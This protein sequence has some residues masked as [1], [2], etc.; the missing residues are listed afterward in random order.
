VVYVVI[1]WKTR[2]GSYRPGGYYPSE[3]KQAVATLRG[4]GIR[5]MMLTGRQQAGRG[6]GGEGD[7][8]R[9]YFAEVPP[10]EKAAIVKRFNRAGCRRIG[11]R[12]GE[13]TPPLLPRR[14][15]N[16]DRRRNRIGRNG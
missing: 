8:N 10:R 7:R 14:R 11:R 6:E 9:E 13:R 2:G 15:G 1:G 16:G 3:S 5:C 12:R 4:L